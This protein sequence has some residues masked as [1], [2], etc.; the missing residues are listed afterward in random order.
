MVELDLNT[1]LL[2][3]RFRILLQSW[4]N[5]DEPNWLWEFETVYRKAASEGEWKQLVERMEKMEKQRDRLRKAVDLGG[6]ASRLRKL[7][8]ELGLLEMELGRAETNVVSLAFARRSHLESRLG[9]DTLSSAEPRLLKASTEA[10]MA[11]LPHLDPPLTQ[12][13]RQHF[14]TFG[15]FFLSRADAAPPLLR[16]SSS[17]SRSSTPTIELNMDELLPRWTNSL[18]QSVRNAVGPGRDGYRDLD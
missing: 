5:L 7:Q 13:E 10:L 18:L 11:K 14:K 16:C 1:P 2:P 9:V 6:E 15:I 17:R 12:Q 8:K 4:A 3:P